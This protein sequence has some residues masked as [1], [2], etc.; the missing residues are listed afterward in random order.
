MN[1]GQRRGQMVKMTNLGFGRARMEFRVPARGLIGFRGQFLTDTR[2]TG[3]LNTMFDGWEPYAGAMNRRLNGAL[4]AAGAGVCTEY[5][6]DHLQ[7]RGVLF[8]GPG[9]LVYEGMVVGEHNR[10]N[11]LEVNIVREK[12]L[13]NVRSKNKD[14]NT[15]LQPPR[16]ITLEYG[17]EFIDRDELMEVTPDAIR[18]RKKVLDT[19]RRPRR[20]AENAG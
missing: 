5:A 8:V 14:E 13:S 16:I 17:L 3:L 18:L 19:S 11:D 15:V 20:D 7:P 1:L 4:V 10:E 9:A 12:K 2:G 6:L